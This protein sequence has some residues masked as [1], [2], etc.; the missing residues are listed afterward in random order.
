MAAIT[1]YRDSTGTDIANTY[2]TKEYVMDWYP[3]LV[4]NMLTPQMWT[5]G[6]NNN[7]NVLGIADGNISSVSSPTTVASGG[8]NWKQVS[9]GNAITAAIKTDGTLWTWG[10]NQRGS[11]G[12]GSSTLG[13][14]SSPVTVSGGGTNWKQV[15]CG[16]YGTN[17]AAVKTDGT[18][19]TWGDNQWGL[20][21]AT[22]LVSRTAPGNVDGGGTNWKQ[23]ACGYGPYGMMAAVKT[24]GTLWTW[25]YNNYGQ[26]GN[27]T[28]ASFGSVTSPVTTVGG[29]G[30]WK[31]VSCSKTHFTAIKTDGTLWTCG[32]NSSGQ[33]GDGTTTNRSSPGTT[34]GGGTNWKQ[35]SC[36]VYNTA[37]IKSDGTLW[38]CGYR[39]GDGTTSTRS[40]PVTTAGGGTNWKQVSVGS[41]CY[42]A[43]KTDGTLWTWGSNV[44]GQ[45]GDGSFTTKTSPVTVSGGGTNWKQVEINSAGG[46]GISEAEG[47]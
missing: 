20:L 23:V 14:I 26:L 5:W 30:T 27:G 31:Q 29:Q 12:N 3:D 43:I 37:A 10:Y 34:A 39:V 9:G 41:S 32:Y 46:R 21:G 7:S 45:L 6:L 1:L 24:D 28:A 13:T 11:L 16:T 8:T 4:S 22:G 35:V 36:G 2:V 38:T 40:S 18:L 25:G 15:N 19:W 44:F 47:W 33:L 17:M 42:S